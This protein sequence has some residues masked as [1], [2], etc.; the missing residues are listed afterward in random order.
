MEGNISGV[1]P[2]DHALVIHTYGNV[3]NVWITTGIHGPLTVK[4]FYYVSL[5]TC[6]KPGN[7]NPLSCHRIPS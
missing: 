5:I 3:N 7:K 2:G 1:T 6:V 4:Y